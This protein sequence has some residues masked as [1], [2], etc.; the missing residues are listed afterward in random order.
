MMSDRASF[1]RRRRRRKGLDESE[2]D[3]AGDGGD[4]DLTMEDTSE[5]PT[6]VR[7]AGKPRKSDGSEGTVEHK[8][9]RAE[10]LSARTSAKVLI[11]ASARL[12]KVLIKPT[13]VGEKGKRKH[14]IIIRR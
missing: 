3:S 4:S 6:R 9:S 5:T 2:E 10:R 7:H 11:A 12:S 13:D 14:K 8:L 1:Y